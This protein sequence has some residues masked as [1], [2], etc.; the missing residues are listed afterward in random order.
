MTTVVGA[1]EVSKICRRVEIGSQEIPFVYQ[2]LPFY[3][4]R[5]PIK[6]FLAL[7][8]VL[9]PPNED[10]RR[11]PRNKENTSIQNQVGPMP[12]FRIRIACQPRSC[13][14]P[15]RHENKKVK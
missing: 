13:F 7:L 9:P 2:S 5:N 1:L 11:Y 14:L 15:K 10:L 8:A 6:P 4:A 12:F 3:Q